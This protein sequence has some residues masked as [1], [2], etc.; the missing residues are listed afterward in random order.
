MDKLTLYHN[1]IE[2]NAR[3]LGKDA[4][5]II[6]CNAKDS[7]SQKNTYSNFDVST[8]FLSSE[9]VNQL[10]DMA[11]STKMNFEIF[12]DEL[13]FIRKIL[14]ID[15][16]SYSKIVVYNSAQSGT[17]P[18]RKT[19]IPSFCKYLNILC[20]GSGAHAVSL[21]RD[22]LATNALLSMNNIPAPK[23]FL[24]DDKLVLDDIKT[25]IAK[26]LYESSSIGISDKN[27]F[28]GKDIPRT[29]LNTLS[30]DLDQPILIQ[31]FICGY[32]IELPI[33]SK[34]EEFFCFDPVCLYLDESKKSMDNRIL[35]YD[36][37]YNDSY[38][39]CDLPINYNCKNLKKT[40]QKVVQLLG[41]N[42]LCRVDF[43]IDTSGKFFVTDVSTNPHFVS[44]SSVNY[45]FSKLKLTPSDIFKS[46]ICLV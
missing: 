35:N 44:H 46:I 40:A 18:G 39:F 38:K 10:K 11:Y 20:T 16:K 27:I 29:Y 36:L 23:S 25:Y 21:C 15:T 37:I 30:N 14:K 4:N 12:F 31:E 17:G 22:K 32:E 24:F 45:A 41:L 6:V 8:E 1:F 42:G 19:L 3:T 26:P 43:R 34:N 33:L 28:S 2:K 5:L 7:S 9:E 13:D